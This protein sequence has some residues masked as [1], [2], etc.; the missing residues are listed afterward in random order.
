MDFYL[1]IISTEINETTEIAN[2]GV[3][4]SS[5]QPTE[6]DTDLASNAETHYSKE[7]CCLR[8]LAAMCYGLRV[9]NDFI[10]DIEMEP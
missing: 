2:D 1:D 3:S 4:P 9:D 7:G 6:Q 5:S 8:V 10:V